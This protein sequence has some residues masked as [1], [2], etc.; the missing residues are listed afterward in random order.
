MVEFKAFYQKLESKVFT[1]VNNVIIVKVSNGMSNHTVNV[2]V[3]G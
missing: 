3:D 2:M 1:D